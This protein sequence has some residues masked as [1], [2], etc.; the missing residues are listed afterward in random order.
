MLLDLLDAVLDLIGEEIHHAPLS[1]AAVGHRGERQS[2]QRHLD[3]ARLIYRISDNG[4]AL[5][6]RAHPPATAA[7]KHAATTADAM[8]AAGSAGQHLRAA[9]DAVHS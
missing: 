5:V 6:R 4:R 9:W 1:Y 8:P 2:L 3:D 7:D